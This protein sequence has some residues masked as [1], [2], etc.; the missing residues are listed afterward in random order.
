M[1][2]LEPLL[3]EVRA[4]RTQMYESQSALDDSLLK[5]SKAIEKHLGSIESSTGWLLSVA[6]YL[7]I[8]LLVAW[9]STR[10]IHC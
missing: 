2:N 9:L 6:E 1:D 5:E 8:F 7:F 3:K 10:V 4:L